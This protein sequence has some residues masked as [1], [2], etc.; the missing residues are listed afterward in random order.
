MLEKSSLL[1]HNWRYVN[2]S[3]TN[4]VF[5]DKLYISVPQ[6]LRYFTSTL[7][8]LWFW[9]FENHYI[10]YVKTLSIIFLGKS[11]YEGLAPWYL[12]SDTFI[13]NFIT[14]TWE[15]I[16]LF[17]MKPINTK[18]F[19]IERV[20]FLCKIPSRIILFHLVSKSYKK[21]VK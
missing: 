10:R 11:Q 18:W 6:S 5:L 17:N 21:G 4:W 15:S 8:L 1:F 13:E 9:K 7:K 16:Q 12:E 14:L 2:M 20:C 3:Q 19:S